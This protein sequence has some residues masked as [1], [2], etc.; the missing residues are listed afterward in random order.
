[1]G[2]HALKTSHKKLVAELKRAIKT[3]EL[4][5]THC[6]YRQQVI[7]AVGAFVDALRD[8]DGGADELARRAGLIDKIGEPWPAYRK[9]AANAADYPNAAG[10][11]KADKWLG[12][13]NVTRDVRR[14]V[15]RL[16][17]GDVP[18]FRADVDRDAT[19]IR[20]V[21]D[22]VRLNAAAKRALKGWL[23]AC[24]DAQRATNNLEVDGCW[25]LLHL[26]EARSSTPSDRAVSAEWAGGAWLKNVRDAA[27]SLMAWAVEQRRG[28]PP[29][30]RVGEGDKGHGGK[31]RS[32]KRNPRQRGR[33]RGNYD[34]TL[35]QK[36]FAA[37]ATLRDFDALAS[38]Y[39]VSTEE[40]R[41]IVKR[42][43]ERERRR[44]KKQSRRRIQST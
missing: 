25:F 43:R 31:P 18:R 2:A 8:V 9:A 20:R 13:R 22:C 30:K 42:H 4:D 21:L 36:I 33:R 17:R 28:A 24:F 16:M 5:W 40:A 44:N 3:C 6:P 41:L 11:A 15:M 26:A 35:H 34:E 12:K 37:S 38:R 29:A 39:G 32:G 7:A 1:M 10:D 19:D 27:N 23:E 14:V